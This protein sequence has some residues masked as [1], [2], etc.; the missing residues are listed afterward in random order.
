MGDATSS[1]VP[2]PAAP[3]YVTARWKQHRDAYER[4]AE[5]NPA[6]HLAGFATSLSNLGL[7]LSALE[8]HDQALVPTEE[9]LTIRRRLVRSNSE[10]HLPDLPRPWTILHFA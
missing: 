3:P 6:A 9:A 2:R 4:L 10:T 5:T 1:G 7:R 8:R